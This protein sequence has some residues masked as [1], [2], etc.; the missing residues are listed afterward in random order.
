M[1]FNQKNKTIP[2]DRIYNWDHHQ[3]IL[4]IE[5]EKIKQKLSMIGINEDTLKIMKEQKSLFES[6]AD[7]VVEKFYEKADS[8]ICF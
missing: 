4:D 5:E 7:R 8:E 3:V 2:P 6:N 1:F